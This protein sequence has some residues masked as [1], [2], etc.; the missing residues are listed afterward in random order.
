VS[1]PE[2]ASAPLRW[3]RALL[4]ATVALLA[5]GLAHLSAGGALPGALGLATLLVLGTAV[6]APLLGTRASTRRVVLLLVLGQTAVHAVLTAASGHHEAEPPGPVMTGPALWL[7]HLGEDLTPAHA[8]MALA[9]GA[10][11]A[12]VGLWLARGEDALWLLVALAG[13]VM[14]PLVRWPASVV[15]T[16]PP[17]VV[18]V[19]G[20]LLPPVSHALASS[21]RRRGPPL[22]C[23]S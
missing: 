13:Q 22:P 14:A 23:A 17:R 7:H 10:A 18:P 19:D 5:G 21:L 8:V 12:A 3:L 9:H 1:R 4:L 20:R 15:M 11:A 2:S 16:A 6:S